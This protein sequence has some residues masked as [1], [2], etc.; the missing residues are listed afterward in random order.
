MSDD[1]LHGWHPDPFGRHEERYFIH[2]E[3]SQLV[4]D[5]GVEAQEREVGG[6]APIPRRDSPLERPTNTHHS[7]AAQS[8]WNTA[9]PS[10]QATAARK[11]NGFAVASL[12]LGLVTAGV[13]SILALIFGYH[14]RRQIRESHGA[15]SGDGMALAGIILGWLGLVG[16][17]IVVVIFIVAVTTHAGNG[18]T[19][20]GFDSPSAAASTP[21]T[22]APLYGANNKE[23]IDAGDT[24]QQEV[25]DVTQAIR[26]YVTD[27]HVDPPDL[28]ALVPL[29][30]SNDP[31]ASPEGPSAAAGYTYDGTAY[32]GGTC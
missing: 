8:P 19:T 18:S 28:S 11:T 31:T 9:S 17:A 7:I 22:H 29:Y 3:L 15:Q 26:N 25:A 2:G 1:A 23:I 5:N 13:G 6:G 30:L 4:R 20:V 32:T 16:T 27:N 21:D 24:C 10:S 12:V 14:A